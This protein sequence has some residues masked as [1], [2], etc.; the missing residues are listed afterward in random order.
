MKTFATLPEAQAAAKTDAAVK[1]VVEIDHRDA[2]RCYIMVKCP[3]QTLAAA[4]RQKPMPEII[5]LVAEY[6]RLT[7]DDIIAERAADDAEAAALA[8]AIPGLDELR[9]AIADEDCYRLQFARMMEDE[10]NDGA[11]PPCDVKV[12]VEAMSLKY[13]RAALYLRAEAYSR[14]ANSDKSLAGD[15]AME[16][17]QSGGSEADA[18]LV[19]ENWL[20]ASAWDN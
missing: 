4:L 19:L 3:M 8:A 16:I 11:R 15:Q 20:P 1:C 17:L 12:S 9:A 5:R 18:V 6:N 13:P 7:Q 14:A 2:G 10:A